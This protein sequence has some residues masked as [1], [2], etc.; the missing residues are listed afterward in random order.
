MSES[1]I[2]EHETQETFVP[3]GASV[4]PEPAL[5]E[6]EQEQALLKTTEE[7]ITTTATKPSRL[8]SAFK[9]I[10]CGLCLHPWRNS[11]LGDYHTLVVTPSDEDG[12][13]LGEDHHG[14]GDG[15]AAMVITEDFKE[16]HIT[17]VGTSSS[18][19]YYR[20]SLDVET[21]PAVQE[22]MTPTFIEE[23]TIDEE[24]TV[25]QSEI[26]EIVQGREIQQ[27]AAQT[28]AAAVIESRPITTP[29]SPTPGRS[30]NPFAKLVKRSSSSGNVPSPSSSPS[31]SSLLGR[32]GRFAKIKRTSET[33]SSIQ[34]KESKVESLKVSSIPEQTEEEVKQTTRTV[35]TSSETI[36]QDYQIQIQETVVDDQETTILTEEPA[37]LIVDTS[38][39]SKPVAIPGQ[40]PDTPTAWAQSPTL[41]QNDISITSSLAKVG[42]S[43][44]IGSANDNGSEAGSVGSGEIQ[45]SPSGGKDGLTE[46]G[47]KRKN[48]VL[49]K[50]GKA[51]KSS[52][53]KVDKRLSRQGSVTLTSPIEADETN[54]L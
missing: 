43:S 26:T 39:T 5:T 1:H 4:T 6:S 23:F 52:K 44:T 19:E 31:T 54:V 16:V 53:D 41:H 30:P 29:S 2:Q 21:K 12:P 13:M 27:E 51:I 20:S 25:Q 35:V 32:F 49:K 45:N 18:V 3:E 7:T 34:S 28:V 38:A 50:I 24:S 40:T 8:S 48:S 10:S 22:Q 47:K 14:S 36:E 11:S 17:D 33:T 46:L 42:R 9:T 15:S 37:S